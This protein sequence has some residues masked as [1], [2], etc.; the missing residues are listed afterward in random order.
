MSADSRRARKRRLCPSR[1]NRIYRIAI[2][3]ISGPPAARPDAKPDLAGNL[4][5]L[6]T[7][8]IC[9]IIYASIVDDDLTGPRQKFRVSGEIAKKASLVNSRDYNCPF[10][11]S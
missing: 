8:I 2:Y 5:P 4:P 11:Y 3:S 10:G 6:I 7:A 1:G 9:A